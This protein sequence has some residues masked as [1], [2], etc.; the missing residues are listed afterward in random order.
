LT[1]H[2]GDVFPIECIRGSTIT[3]VYDSFSSAWQIPMVMLREFMDSGYF[4]V[5]SN[6]S[7]PLPS[8]FRKAHSVGLEI[9]K[10]LHENR[11]A[12]I[13]LFGTRYSTTRPEIPNVF[14]LDKVEPET[15]NPKIEK[16]YSNEIS[17]ISGKREILRVIYT[18][19]GVSLMLGEDNTLKL[20]NQTLATIK[21]N[22]TLVLT[23]NQDVVSKRFVGWVSGVSD[24]LLL[25]RSYIGA[26]FAREY[27]YL[28]AAPCEDF[29]PAVYEMRV[30]RKKGKERFEIKELSAPELGPPAE[31]KR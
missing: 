11:M 30:T 12:V 10:A 2:L 23:L 28:M 31:E 29:E 3:V 21:R 9:E 8:L 20:L 13:D 7:L 26:G 18:L 4:G 27:L 22:Q 1:L 17:R 14:Y 24:V 6:Y 19:D 5:F 25:V 15:L 16:I